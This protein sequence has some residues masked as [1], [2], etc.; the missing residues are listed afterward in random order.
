MPHFALRIKYV[1]A[2]YVIACLLL[3]LMNV[4]IYVLMY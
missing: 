3:W 2:L 4:N 1:I